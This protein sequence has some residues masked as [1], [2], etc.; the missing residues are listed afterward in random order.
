MVFPPDFAHGK[1]SALRE[2]TAIPIKLNGR[3]NISRAV[4]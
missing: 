3:E 4:T 2:S 1:R